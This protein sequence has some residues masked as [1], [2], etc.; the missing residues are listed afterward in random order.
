MLR[1][2][3]LEIFYGEIQALKG[4]SLDVP[5][6]SIVTV[7]GANGAGKSTTLKTISGLLR[8]ARG[9]IK[10][11]ERRIDGLSPEEIVKLGISQVPEGRGV[12]PDMTAKENLLLGAFV[13]K[14]KEAINEDL[15]RVFQHF[16]TLKD[17]QNQNAGKLSGGEQQMLG[18]GRALMSKP[19]M[20]VLDEP[21]LGLSPLLVEEI[22]KIIVD[23]NRGGTTILLVEQNANVALSISQYGYILETGKISLSGATRDLLNNEEVK[24]SYLGM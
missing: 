23:I 19:K 16:P 3:D 18:I 14:D 24:R 15:D 4:I 10:F 20:L 6:E 17:R 13:R 22:F 12:F 5:A 1:I 8:P 7:L 9:T 21:S 11:N 2:E